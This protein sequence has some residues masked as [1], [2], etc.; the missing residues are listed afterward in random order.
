M[1]GVHEI[2]NQD[3]GL[4][5]KWHQYKVSWAS[6]IAGNCDVCSTFRPDLQP[7]HIP[8]SNYWHFA[9]RI[10]WDSNEETFPSHEEIHLNIFLTTGKPHFKQDVCYGIFTWHLYTEVVYKCEV[11]CDVDDKEY[12]VEIQ[13]ILIIIFCCKVWYKNKHLTIYRFIGWDFVQ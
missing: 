9:K 7:R 1:V 3:K 6:Q 8:A 13:D 2:F 10:H 12:C 11:S 5:I 4:N